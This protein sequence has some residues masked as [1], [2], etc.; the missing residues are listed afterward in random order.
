MRPSLRCIQTCPARPKTSRE[1]EPQMTVS[2][3][4]PL[5]LSPMR[6]G[7]VEAPN[8]LFMGAHGLRNHFIGGPTGRLVPTANAAAYYE[9]RAAGG[10]GLIMHSFAVSGG[11]AA[12]PASEAD[13]PP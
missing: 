9:E 6:I 10:V 2:A 12:G 4:Y 8:R 1:E 3:A 13:V 11:L 5:S 7:P